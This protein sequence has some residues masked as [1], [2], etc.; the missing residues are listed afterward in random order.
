MLFGDLMNNENKYVFSQQELRELQLKELE[1][2]L[3]FK[4][5]CDKHDLKF[6]FCGGC[7]I[8]SLRSGG[9]IPWDDDIDVFMLRRDYETFLKL[10]KQEEDE[11]RYQLLQTDDEIFTRNIFATLVDK[12]YTCVKDY[13]A[14]LDIPHGLVM[15]IFPLDA[16][17]GGYKRKFQKMWALIYSLYRAQIVPENH[18]RLLAFG[19]RVLL[20]LV[21][22]KKMR[23]RLWRKAERKMT[24]YNLDECDYITELCAGP[25]YMQNEYPK[26]DFLD[27]VMYDFEGSKMPIP[28][29]YDEYLSIAFG[30]YKRIPPVEEQVPH[31][32]VEYCDL[33]KPCKEYDDEQRS[34]G[35]YQRRV[36]K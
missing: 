12:N 11:Q 15:D 8:G 23:N 30:D 26:A 9:F 17:P 4:N 18:G 20:A 16:C 19:S 13:Q 34:L 10:W 29:G 25:H 1:T 5:F 27:V 32:D 28:V 6:C 22:S 24:K 21:P 7:C 2:L 31:H 36:R 14:D 3:Y 35:K 33:S